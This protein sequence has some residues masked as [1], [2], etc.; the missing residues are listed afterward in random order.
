[1][2]SEFYARFMLN[3]IEVSNLWSNIVVVVHVPALPRREEQTLPSNYPQ[4]FWFHAYRKK[5]PTDKSVAVR[6]SILPD[7]V[8]AL[9]KREEP[10]LFQDLTQCSREGEY[11]LMV[12][13]MK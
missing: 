5:L 3:N 12:I 10:H 6:P 7:V 4:L 11:H 2:A 13:L 1:M 8:R 9:G